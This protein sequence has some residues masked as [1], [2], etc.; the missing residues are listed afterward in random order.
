MARTKFGDHNSYKSPDR[1]NQID[2]N[3]KSIFLEVFKYY[4]GLIRLRKNHPAFR[5]TSSEQIREHLIF[6]EDYMPGVASYVL[7]NHANNDE[8]R[9]ILIIF[10]GN[11][12]SIKFSTK[13]HI[14]WRVVAHNTIIDEESTIYSKGKE[15][16]VSGISMLMM[17]ED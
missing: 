14:T 15:V 13:K 8:W 12:Q 5:M 4:Q 9:T 2:W 7:V 3:R 10:N 11:A 1:I 6:S 17:V 16:E